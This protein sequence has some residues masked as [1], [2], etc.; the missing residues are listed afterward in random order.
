MT[1]NGED[2]TC[3]VSDY[4]ERCWTQSGFWGEPINAVTN[5]AFLAA[6]LWALYEARSRDRLDCLSGLLCANLAAIGVGS[7]LWHT[8]ATPW[9]KLLDVLPIVTMVLLYFGAILVRAHR[10]S[11]AQAALIL[12]AF[13]LA[14]TGFAYLVGATSIGETNAG[15]MAAWL[16]I[17]G[18]AAVLAWR[19]HDLAPWLCA[20]AGIFLASIAMRMA[21]HPL[22]DSFP[23]GTHFLWHLL[24]GA[25]FG[26]LL[27]GYVRHCPR[28]ARREGNR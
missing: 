10:V 2:W 12:V 5:G 13:V 23:I 4:C 25:L 20:G 11:C 18:N 17:V 9:A 8:L 15:Y 14:A 21:D 26:V 3:I 22:C 19:G 7:F 28:E 1:G 24:N 6:A 27:T 16:L